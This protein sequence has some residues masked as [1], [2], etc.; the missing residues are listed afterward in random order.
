MEDFGR[1]R[2][3]SPIYL[4]EGRNEGIKQSKK[5]R[6]RMKHHKLALWLTMAIALFLPLVSAAQ[7]QTTK[8]QRYKL[9]GTVKSVDTK[10]QK[11]DVDG[12]DIPG[13]MGAMTMTYSA[14]KTEDLKKVS[15]GDQIQADVVVGDGPTHLENIK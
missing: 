7:T 1:D 5:R 4:D 11:V 6:R 8:I 13:F 10:G 15:S 12:K 3:P 14:G 2:G 9:V